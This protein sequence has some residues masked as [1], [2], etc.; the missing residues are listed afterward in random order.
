M[1]ELIDLEAWKLKKLIGEV[2]DVIMGLDPVTS[3]PL[4]MD[5]ATGKVVQLV[6]IIMKP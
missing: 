2:E 3:G 6:E 4:W 1:G 5:L